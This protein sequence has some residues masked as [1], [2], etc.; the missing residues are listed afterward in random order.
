LDKYFDYEDVEEDRKVKHAVTRIKGYATLWW[1]EL[2]DER[3]C[4]GKKKIKSWDI[5]VVKMKVK[6]IPK[7]DQI[8]L[9]RRMK[10]LIEK[11]MSMEYTKEFYKLNIGA[12]HWER[13][14][15]KV[16]RYMNGMTYDIQ[17]DMSMMIIQTVEYSYQMAL[18]FEEKLRRN[19]G[20]RGRGRS[21][22]RGKTIAQDRN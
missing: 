9:F 1:D 3:H 10:N 15:E 20:Q 7:G 4:K 12:S 6:F 13:D 16:V 11:L 5:M 21:Q 19:Q 18:K 17:Y 22:A 2:K 14:Y 8:T